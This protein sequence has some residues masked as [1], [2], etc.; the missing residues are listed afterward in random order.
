MLK[1]MESLQQR[2]PDLKVFNATKLFSPIS[3]SPN[4]ALL[5]RNGSLWLQIFIEH[6]C[7]NGG[8][9]FDELGLKSEL[10]GFLDTFQISCGGFKM[11]QA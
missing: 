5:H 11:H 2:F 9:F 6:F 3:F 10:Q 7:T 1:V 8:N 4:L